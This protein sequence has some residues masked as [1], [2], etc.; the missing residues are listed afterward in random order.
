[1]DIQRYVRF[2]IRLL[3][4]LLLAGCAAK[5]QAGPPT[6]PQAVPEAAATPEASPQPS[7]TPAEQAQLPAQ[8][9]PPPEPEPNPSPA[10]NDKKASNGKQHGNS[11]KNSTQNNSARET[12]KNTPPKIVVRP[13]AEPTPSGGQISPGGN[14]VGRGEASTDQLL[15]SAE[16]NLNNLKRQLSTDEQAIVTQIR[17]FI[18]KSRQATK[19]NDGIRAH[20]LAVKAQE[21][22]DDLMKRR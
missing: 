11:K 16:N 15:Q 4:A 18:S 14:D 20:N 2:V 13:D 9:T 6:P 17:D 10:A 7:A 22:S 12:A 19:D 21:M 3:L 1:M 5:K 8:G